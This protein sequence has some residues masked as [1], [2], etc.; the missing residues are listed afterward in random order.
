MTTHPRLR[1][2]PGQ[3]LLG[4]F[5]VGQLCFIMAANFL[6]VLRSA[7]AKK[8]EAAQQPVALVMDGIGYWAWGTGQLQGWSQYAP[9]VPAQSA[10]IAVELRWDE[11]SHWP[12][13]PDVPRQVL[14]SAI[15]PDD[16]Q[17]YSRPFGSF[18]LSTYEAKLSL[19]S[20]A[21]DASSYAS[22]PEEWHRRFVAA[23]R[24]DWRAMQAY[25]TWRWSS[26]CRGQGPDASPPRQALLLARLYEIPPPGQRPWSWG[27]PVE[28]P[29]AR[30]CPARAAVS[31]CLPIE[32]Y[33]PL[34]RRFEPVPEEAPSDE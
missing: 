28:Q 30:W 20:W 14:H 33:N 2:R 6:P 5:V 17:S 11:D 31:D 4:L 3:V 19:V 7:L 18:R 29:V 26:Y 22:E 23:V 12:A 15:E 21:W 24:K 9:A 1:P 13:P 25:L 16:P 10:F 34:T 8:S 27:G 32:A